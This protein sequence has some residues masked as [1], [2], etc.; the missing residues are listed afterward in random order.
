MGVAVIYKVCI[1]HKTQLRAII[2]YTNE[3]VLVRKLGVDTKKGTG[4]F[5]KNGG[6]Y[7]LWVLLQCL[8]GEGSPFVGYLIG[9]GEFLS[10]H[11]YD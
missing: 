7:V 6:E 4:F 10:N 11:E 8:L 1:G 9:E 2:G 5:S 3:C